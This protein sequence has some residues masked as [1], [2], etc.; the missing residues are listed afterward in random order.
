MR[1]EEVQAKLSELLHRVAP[2]VELS[3]LGGTTKLREELELDSFDF[4]QLLVA[5]QKETRVEI[6]E[7]D[8]ASVTTWGGLVDYVSAQLQ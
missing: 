5:I 8:Y 2:D 7:R 6:P 3:A 1:R 4:L